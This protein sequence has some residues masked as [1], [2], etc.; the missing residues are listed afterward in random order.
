MKKITIYSIVFVALFCWQ[1]PVYAADSV[2]APILSLLLGDDKEC[3]KLA[4]FYGDYEPDDDSCVDCYWQETITC[5][6]SKTSYSFITE[7]PAALSLHGMVAYCKA[8]CDGWESINTFDFA[9]FAV[10]GGVLMIHTPSVA[11]PQ[12]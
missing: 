4:I 7:G 5:Y 6:S 2:V 1:S 12:N 11:T 8:M 9:D 3:R 10:P